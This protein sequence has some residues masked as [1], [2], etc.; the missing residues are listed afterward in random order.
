VL[1]IYLAALFAALGAFGVQLLGGHHDIGPGHDVSHGGTGHE[2]SAWSLVASIRFWAFSLLAF[3]LVGTALTVFGLAGTVVTALL[4]TASG[5]CSG[6]FAA[7][8]VRRLV[9]RPATSHVASSDVVGRLGRVLV[10]LVPGGRGK[11]RVEVKGTVVD[12][13]A[14]SRETVD[15]GEAV[16]VEEAN[17]GEVVVSRAPKELAP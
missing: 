12:Y 17:E 14:R 10:P 3:G 9:S 15:A 2:P 4:A 5:V 13:V 1:S 16:L 11:V 7:S 6:V 8:V